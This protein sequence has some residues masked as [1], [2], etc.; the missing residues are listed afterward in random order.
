MNGRGYIHSVVAATLVVA[1][2]FSWSAGGQAQTF[3][4]AARAA[5]LIDAETGQVLFEKN[6]DQPYEPAS[7]VKIMTLLVAMDAVKAGRVSLADPVR[8]SRRAAAVGG[9]QVYL[10]EGETHPLEKMLKAVAI[11]SGNDASMAVAEFIAGTEDAFVQL[12]NERARQIGM[13]QSR[14]TNADGL[15]PEPGEEP[16][17]ASARDIALASR[18]LILEHPK[19]LE[20][21]STVM[22][23]FRENPLFILY[24][25]NGLVGKYEGLDGLKTGHTTAAGWC[26]AATAVRGNVRL[27]SV[28]MGAESRAAREEQTRALLDYGF[29]RFA[30][31]LAG[32]GEVGA[33]KVVTGIPEQVPV[34]VERPVWAHVPRGQNVELV[35][36]IVTRP[37]L[38]APIAQGEHVGEYVVYLGGQ[39]AFRV[40]V[41]AAVDVERA[42]VFVRAWRAVRDFVLDLVGRGA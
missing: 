19:V 7:L 42:S 38:V 24:N 36:E 11:A 23:T 31:V 27:I 6:A 39:E 4:V 41:Y 5:I 37:D 22:E 3:D 25:T 12:M 20:W 26:L 2:L 29:N 9:S 16:S 18:T 32:E 8:T 35:T 15:P 33:A 17:L 40:P 13:T 28:I 21:T 1:L 34:R 10:A 30:P 14:F